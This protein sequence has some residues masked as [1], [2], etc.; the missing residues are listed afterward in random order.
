MGRT[1]E[2]QLAASERARSH[3]HPCVITPNP[4]EHAQA[5]FTLSL[6][7]AE[8]SEEDP[9]IWSG[10]VNHILSDDEWIDD[11]VLESDDDIEEI[12]SQE[13]IQNTRLQHCTQQPEHVQPSRENAFAVLMQKKTG[14]DWVSGEKKLKIKTGNSNKRKREIRLDL[15]RRE[16]VNSVSRNR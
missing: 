12:T 11:D 15:E 7:D 1:S 8:I 4:G 6:D 2:A 9:T 5:S 13:I 10:G 14:K 16:E 3:R